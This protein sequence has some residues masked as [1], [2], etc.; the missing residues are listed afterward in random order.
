MAS[1]RSAVNKESLI[2]ESLYHFDCY[3]HQRQ[4]TPESHTEEVIY[5]MGRMYAHLNLTGRAMDLF[6]EVVE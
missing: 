4:S 5:N 3:R 1:S 6:Q 2:K